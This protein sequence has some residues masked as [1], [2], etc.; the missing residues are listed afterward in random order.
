MLAGELQVPLRKLAAGGLV[1]DADDCG[2][3]KTGDRFAREALAC[4]VL[5]NTGGGGSDSGDH[6]F[7]ASNLLSGTRYTLS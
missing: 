1:L 3:P 4:D 2:H 7:V 6:F 5:I